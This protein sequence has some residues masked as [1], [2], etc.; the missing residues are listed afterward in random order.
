[1]NRRHQFQLPGVALCLSA[2]TVVTYGIFVHPTK[3]DVLQ[4][5]NII[6]DCQFNSTELCVWKL[7][8]GAIINKSLKDHE[9]FH[10]LENGGCRLTISN[11]NIERDEGHVQCLIFV[12]DNHPGG[13]VSNTVHINVIVP[14]SSLYLSYNGHKLKNNSEV[15]I[16]PSAHETGSFVCETSHGNP[17]S[18]IHW[19]MNDNDRYNG[20]LSVI[21]EADATNLKRTTSVLVLHLDFK[22]N[23]Q[24]L[25]C[26]VEHS[27]NETS[28]FIVNVKILSDHLL[29]VEE[30]DDINFECEANGNPR[31]KF[32]W[33]FKAVDKNEWQVISNKPVFKEMA[34]EPRE[35]KYL[36]LAGNTETMLW[37]KEMTVKVLNRALGN[38]ATI[39]ATFCAIAIVALFTI[40]LV[41]VLKQRKKKQKLETTST[42]KYDGSQYFGSAP[43][44]GKVT[45]K[46]ESMLKK[47]NAKR[48]SKLSGPMDAYGYM[49]ARRPLP[50]IIEVDND[51]YV[52][53]D[54]VLD[55]K[56]ISSPR[57]AN[58][59][60]LYEEP[61]VYENTLTRSISTIC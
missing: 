59:M 28:N 32:E 43:V 57:I 36:C 13:L 2:F 33:R 31:P 41:T 51:Q 16:K 35:G 56:P 20:D 50:A 45:G 24:I 9:I 6:L 27:F 11:V 40:I 10:D 26:I 60:N 54:P 53:F 21:E 18:R 3:R 61:H 34:E 39:P 17:A 8:N 48:K 1:M 47:M 38:F 58:E 14:P 42:I 5:E 22:M 30:G 49:V 7:Q 15:K 23:A 46:S 25:M 4:G 55:N 19:K 37:S 29:S 44:R 12:S 52:G